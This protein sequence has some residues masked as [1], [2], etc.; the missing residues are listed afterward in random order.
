MGQQL[1]ANSRRRRRVVPLRV[2]DR[3]WIG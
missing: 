3:L 2:S 1:T